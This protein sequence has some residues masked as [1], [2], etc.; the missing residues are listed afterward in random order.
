MMGWAKFLRVQFES[1]VWD[2]GL[3][4]GAVEVF[5]VKHGGS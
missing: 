3:Q 5:G 2:I 4:G 1:G